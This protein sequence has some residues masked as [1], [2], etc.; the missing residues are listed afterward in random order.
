MNFS[1][2]FP[3]FKS[4][5]LCIDGIPDLFMRI[6]NEAN[7]SLPRL[8]CVNSLLGYSDCLRQFSLF[9]AFLV[10]IKVCFVLKA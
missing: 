1:W 6:G 5:E 3:V 9:S 7:W 4:A 8:P 2:V 10:E